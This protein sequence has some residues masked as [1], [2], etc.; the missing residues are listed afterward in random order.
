M[1]SIGLLNRIAGLIG[2]LWEPN[3]LKAKTVVLPI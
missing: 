3:I 2:F 1:M